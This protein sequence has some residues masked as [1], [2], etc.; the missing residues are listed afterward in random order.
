MGHAHQVFLLHQRV[1]ADQQLGDAPVL[2]QH[3]QAGGI[4]VQPAGRRQ[5]AGMAGVEGPLLVGPAVGRGDQRGRGRVAVLGLAADIAHRLVEQDGHAARLFLARGRVDVDALLGPHALAQHG[6]LAVHA[7]PA[8]GDPV[9]GL[10]ARGDALVGEP[11]GHADA[12]ARPAAGRRR[13]RRCQLGGRRRRAGGGEHAALRPGRGRRLR[14]RPRS[15]GGV[16][17]A[18]TLGRRGRS[19][20]RFGSCAG[21][22]GVGRGRRRGGAVGLARCVGGAHAQPLRVARLRAGFELDR[23]SFGHGAPIGAQP[24][25]H[26]RRGRRRLQFERVSLAAR[27]SRALWG[28]AGRPK[29][30]ATASRYC[31]WPT[32]LVLWCEPPSTS[33]KRFGLRACS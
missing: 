15:G 28:K 5:A 19:R 26:G 6:H 32:A 18:R 29:S 33:T 30:S 12:F 2:R 9:V 1:F 16:R 31:A 11:F 22:L 14:R 4:D 25:A 27:T 8:G 23:G 24:L 10:A 13:P 20:R 17:P 21:R 7:H 3:Q